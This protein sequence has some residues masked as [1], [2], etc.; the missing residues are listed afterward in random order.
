MQIY[1]L[2][3]TVLSTAFINI[4]SRKKSFIFVS[5]SEQL[6]L[7]TQTINTINHKSA[8]KNFN[9]IENSQVPRKKSYVRETFTLKGFGKNKI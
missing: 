2:S 6:R 5:E 4:L 9:H 8:L 3:N 7:Y 1:L